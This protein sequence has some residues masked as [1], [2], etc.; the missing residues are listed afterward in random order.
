MTRS[1]KSSCG[2]ILPLSKK[3]RDWLVNLDSRIWTETG[4]DRIGHYH[5]WEKEE[6]TKPVWKQVVGLIIKHKLPVELHSGSLGNLSIS[7]FAH[8]EAPE[9]PPERIC[10][11]GQGNL[12]GFEK[13]RGYQKRHPYAWQTFSPL[14]HSDRNKELLAFYGLEPSRAESYYEY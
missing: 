3:D 7:I 10:S 1:Q 6:L 13:K 14:T 4:P 11:I 2:V 9:I 5:Y 12:P 8:G